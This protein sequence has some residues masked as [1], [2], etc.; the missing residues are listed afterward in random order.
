MEPKNPFDLIDAHANKKVKPESICVNC[1]NLLVR[2]CFDGVI[3]SFILIECKYSHIVDIEEFPV[4]ECT[5][6]EQAER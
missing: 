3:D 1:K 2:K 6:F 5:L 4:L